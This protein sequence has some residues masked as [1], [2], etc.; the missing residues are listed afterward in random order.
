MYGIHRVTVAAYFSCIAVVPTLLH[1]SGCLKHPFP[2]TLDI[3]LFSFRFLTS[4]VSLEPN[5]FLVRIYREF[6]WYFKIVNMP[7]LSQQ[8]DGDSEKEAS[9]LLGSWDDSTPEGEERNNEICNP[10]IEKTSVRNRSPSTARRLL[11][12]LTTLILVVFTLGFSVSIRS[13]LFKGPKDP[14]GLGNCTAT[15]LQGPE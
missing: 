15:S 4:P 9:A 6:G 5:L 1:P 11:P 2:W 14:S 8:P 3:R 7:S 10:E 12:L 13:S